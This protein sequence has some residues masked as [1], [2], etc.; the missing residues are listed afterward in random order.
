MKRGGKGPVLRIFLDKPGRISLD[1][2]E[3]ASR[4]ISAIL[5]VED[6][7]GRSYTLEV[8]SP[9]MTRPLKT[10]ADFMRVIEKNVQIAFVEAPASV[11][12]DA[13][14]GDADEAKVPVKEIK[15][16]LLAVN[17]K[18]VRIVPRDNK[19]REGAEI[20]VPFSALRHAQREISFR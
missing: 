6:P 12:S 8:S 9:G 3:S 15:G 16:R 5:D 7:I 13:A 4:E 19:G 20:A 1:E 18:E 17:D 2:L 10:P 11:G 14:G